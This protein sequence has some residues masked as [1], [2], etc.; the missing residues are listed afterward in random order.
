MGVIIVVMYG[1]VRFKFDRLLAQD[2]DIMALCIVGLVRVTTSLPWAISM[3]TAMAIYAIAPDYE[4]ASEYSSTPKAL[5][6]G[7]DS[8][9]LQVNHCVPC[10]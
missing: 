2:Q 8:G 4:Q 10:Q 5:K 3:N 1:F 6:R 9:L 7:T